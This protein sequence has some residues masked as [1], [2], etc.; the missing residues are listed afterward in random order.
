[1]KITPREATTRL[2]RQRF[3][4]D[5]QV[6]ALMPPEMPTWGHDESQAPAQASGGRTR[7]RTRRWV[8]ASAGLATALV[9][10][11][12]IVVPRL[13][14]PAVAAATPPL[15]EYSE[16]KREGSASD[17]ISELAQHARSQPPLPGNGPYHYV[18]T[19]Q[20][21]LTTSMTTDMEVMDARVE[22]RL[23]EQ[24]IARDGSGRI[25]QTTDGERENFS[26]KF[27]PRAG[28]PP[29]LVGSEQELRSRLLREG[30][31]RTSGDWFDVMAQAWSKQVVSPDLQAALLEI[32]AD[33]SDVEVR[34]MT[35]DRQGREGIAIGTDTTQRD[36]LAPEM[37]Y[38]LVLDPETGMLL[39]Y[40]VIAL[41][42]G[43]LPI[44]P[45]A[46]VSYIVLL[47]SGYMPDTDSRPR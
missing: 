44:D 32:L 12:A 14:E 47:K 43:D 34:G 35:T 26:G 17:M 9:A 33:R 39:D 36:P 25:E 28:R 10:A 27:G 15:L 13:T 23:R 22:E 6:R 40:E 8:L 20:F 38:V 46:T 31:D 4:S 45:P 3:P 41:E 18:N 21:Q 11:G 19:R 24:W 29:L 30:S 2:A 5:E 7:V 42:A 1:M 37:R 16:L